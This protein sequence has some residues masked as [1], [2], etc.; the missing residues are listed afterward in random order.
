MA[1]F[2]HEVS[3]NYVGMFNIWI[4]FAPKFCLKVKN[5]G[6]EANIGPTG[7]PLELPDNRSQSKRARAGNSIANGFKIGPRH[8][9]VSVI[10]DDFCNDSLEPFFDTI[11]Y[12]CIYGIRIDVH[13]FLMLFQDVFGYLSE[14]S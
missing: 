11:Y 8:H 10:F 6:P 9:K 12:V 4:K 3:N 5:I 14:T 13:I 1:P 7:Y 2:V